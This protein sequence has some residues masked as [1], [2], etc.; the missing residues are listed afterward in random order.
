MKEKVVQLPSF[1]TNLRTVNK[2]KNKVTFIN[3]DAGLKKNK[4]KIQEEKNIWAK[5]DLNS[6]LKLFI[7]E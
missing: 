4:I 3:V 2:V 1:K 7:M 5:L 6:T